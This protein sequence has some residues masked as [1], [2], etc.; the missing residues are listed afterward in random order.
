M[1]SENT[2]P[3]LWSFLFTFLAG[4]IW[5]LSVIFLKWGPQSRLHLPPL[6]RHSVQNQRWNSHWRV[7]LDLSHGI[8]LSGSEKQGSRSQNF[9]ACYYPP[10]ISPN[11]ASHVNSGRW[12]NSREDSHHKKG[13]KEI[14]INN[15]IFRHVPTCAMTKGT[16]KLLL[17][18]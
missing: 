5:P 6:L 15:T 4:L 3:R 7:K 16:D 2:N 17:H 1:F 13:G 11:T 10:V 8:H 18:T 14:K 9:I 12:W